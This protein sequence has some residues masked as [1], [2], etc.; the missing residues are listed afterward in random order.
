MASAALSLCSPRVCPFSAPFSRRRSLFIAL[1]LLSSPTSSAGFA[2]VLTNQAPFPP[3]LSALSAAVAC[4]TNTTSQARATASSSGAHRQGPC[5]RVPRRRRSPHVPRTLSSPSAQ[6]TGTAW[7][8]GGRTKAADGPGDELLC[9]WPRVGERLAVG[10]PLCRGPQSAPCP[11]SLGRVW[12]R[13]GRISRGSLV[14]SGPGR[15]ARQRPPP[16]DA[17]RTRHR[18]LL[19]ALPPL[20]GVA[21]PALA[22]RSPFAV[23]LGR[24]T[25]DDLL[26]PPTAAMSLDRTSDE[27]PLPA[28]LGPFRRPWPIH[29]PPSF[30]HLVESARPPPACRCLAACTV[31]GHLVH[32]RAAHDTP[33][34]RFSA[35]AEWPAVVVILETPTAQCG[36]TMATIGPE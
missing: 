17:R 22:R 31:S 19:P 25:I 12:T 15:L 23:L 7:R 26:P 27:D 29:Q 35:G 30:C 24:S 32:C 14:V 3:R 13:R 36:R 28:P 20:D 10:G 33:R 21:R 16:A 2:H 6:P 4:T 5:S 1:H 9:S 8:L 11:I 18:L 34:P